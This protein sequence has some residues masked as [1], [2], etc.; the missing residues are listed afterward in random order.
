MSVASRIVITEWIRTWRGAGAQ[1]PKPTALDLA[2]QKHLLYLMAMLGNG[3]FEE[4]RIESESADVV[5]AV[6]GLLTGTGSAKRI[7]ES[8]ATRSSRVTRDGYLIYQQGE[9]G[10]FFV[11]PL[12]RPDL[13][14]DE[15]LVTYL[16]EF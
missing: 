15:G 5:A 1:Q 14:T 11:N 10:Y 12:P 7:E 4:V 3:E 2:N 13:F 8:A 6:Q 9:D 16:S